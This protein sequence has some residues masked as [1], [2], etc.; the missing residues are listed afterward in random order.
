M[1]PGGTVLGSGWGT[2]WRNPSS[3]KVKKTRPSRTRAPVAAWRAI[4]RARGTSTVDAARTVAVASMVI[5][6]LVL[7]RGFGLQSGDEQRRTGSTRPMRFF[8]T[9]R[10]VAEVIDKAKSARRAP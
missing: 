1:A 8:A 10:Q 4:A 5:S 6:P 9:H 3:P 2:K 7:G